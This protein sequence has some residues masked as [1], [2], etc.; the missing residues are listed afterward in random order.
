M[1]VQWI[2]AVEL[3]ENIS[4]LCKSKAEEFRMIG[5]EHVTGKEV[6]ACVSAKYEKEGTPSLHKLVND[7]LSL[8]VTAFMNFMTMAAYKGNTFD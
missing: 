2:N 4:G 8:K 5:Y 3:D 1:E 6:W 7:I